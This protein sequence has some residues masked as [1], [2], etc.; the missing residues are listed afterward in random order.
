MAGKNRWDGAGNLVA[1]AEIRYTQSNQPVT[2]FRLACNERFY[3][4]GEQR[5]RTEYVNCVLWG[6]R[7]PAMVA[8][9]LLN[10][11][12]GLLVEGRLQS[13]S[14]PHKTATMPDGTP[15]KMYVTEVVIG[16]TDGALQLI[17][18]GGSQTQPQDDVPPPRDED[19]SGP[20]T[21]EAPDGDDF[22]E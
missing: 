2:S 20:A 5:E 18:R 16:N 17:G 9:G 12:Q 6:K 15:V 19:L 10:K 21:S 4:N 14:Y 1:N 11:G 3:S 7:G 22:A 13:R 8:A